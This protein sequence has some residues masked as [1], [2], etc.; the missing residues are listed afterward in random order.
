VKAIDKGLA[1]PETPPEQRRVCT[2]LLK[3]INIT[4]CCVFQSQMAQAMAKNWIRDVQANPALNSIFDWPRFETD[5]EVYFIFTVESVENSLKKFQETDVDQALAVSIVGKC[6]RPNCDRPRAKNPCTGTIYDFCSLRCSRY[7]STGL[8]HDAE[9]ETESFIL[10]KR[11]IKFNSILVT[12]DV[13][14]VI[15]LEMSRLQMIEDQMKKQQR[16]MR[17]GLVE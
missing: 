12:A 17:E 7:S 6:N 13:D 4:F 9:S 3:N 16:E 10:N 14:L 8:Q 11:N 1:P 15:A 2:T 5:Q